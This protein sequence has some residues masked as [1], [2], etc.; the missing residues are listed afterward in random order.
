MSFV[1]SNNTTPT[2]WGTQFVYIFHE[3][4]SRYD[5]EYGRFF[6]KNYFCPLFSFRF[7]AYMTQPVSFE[8][9]LSHKLKTGLYTK[10]LRSKDSVNFSTHSDS[11]TCMTN[12]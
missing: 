6:N 4:K 9:C 8:N 5:S 1:S 11:R 7:T 2:L 12:E 10:R 3:S